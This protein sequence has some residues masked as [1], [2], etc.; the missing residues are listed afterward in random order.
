MISIDEAIQQLLN[1]VI[2]TNDIETVDLLDC[3]HR[4]LAKTQTSNINV[5]PADVSAMDGYA[6]ALNQIK[7]NISYPISQ[8]VPAGH[9]ANPLQPNSVVRIF[10]GSEIPC[11]ADTVVIQENCESQQGGIVVKELPN[12]GANIRRAGQDIINGAT[13]LEKGRKLL[14]QDLGLLASIG[15]NQVPC[16]RQLKVGVISSGDELIEPGNT[17]APGKIFNSNAFTLKGLI[18]GAGFEYVRLGHIQD[19]FE[20]T[21]NALLDA[22]NKVDVI[23]STGG[24]SVGEEDH[25]KAAVQSIGKLNLWKL[26]IKPGKPLAYGRINSTPF[27]GLPGNPVAVFVTFLMIV[28][29]YLFVM[30]GSNQLPPEPLKLQCD[31]TVNKPS[32]RQE[33]RRVQIQGNRVV[34]FQTQ[35]SGVLSSTHWANALAV[36]PAETKIAQCDVVD[37]YPFSLFNV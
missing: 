31:F 28:R 24:V 30:Q 32:P 2:P 22:A 10:T 18:T 14:A 3:H 35:D 27:F 25:I 8:R 21:K 17:L 5:P 29:R 23:V 9:P 12:I 20:D 34:E 19:N 16:F 13:L 26:A 37:V 4:V 6:F 1:D 33:Y 11:G 36:I 7:P 15:I